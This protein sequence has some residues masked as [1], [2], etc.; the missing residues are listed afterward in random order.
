MPL[1]RQDGQNDDNRIAAILAQDFRR[2]RSWGGAKALD[3]DITKKYRNIKEKV[4]RH[5]AV[6]YD[7]ND[8]L[9]RLVKV[10]A[11]HEVVALQTSVFAAPILQTLATVGA[12][13][14]IGTRG[15]RAWRCKRS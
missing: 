10:G 15:L 12:V 8:L 4:A 1:R 7:L 9:H 14:P 5:E 3:R 6:C 11:G 13:V 2:M